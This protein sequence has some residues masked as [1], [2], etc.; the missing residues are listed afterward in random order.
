MLTL[1]RIV[2]TTVFGLM[3][4]SCSGV[5]GPKGNDS[6]G[7]IPWHPE[8]EENEMLIAQK[9]CDIWNKQAV[10][11]NISREPGGYINYACRSR[12]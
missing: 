4:T 9:Q 2:L 6:G 8:N 10:I 7:I 12:Y 5:Y 11:T 3:L 1:R